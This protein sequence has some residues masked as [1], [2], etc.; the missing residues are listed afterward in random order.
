MIAFTIFFP[1][2]ARIA[3]SRF[4]RSPRLAGLDFRPRPAGSML[5][6]GIY[7]Y[8][9]AAFAA[10]TSMSASAVGIN[11]HSFLTVAACAIAGWLAGFA[12]PGSPAGVR[13][14]DSVIALGLSRLIDPGQA[15]LVARLHRLI[16]AVGDSIL[17]LAGHPVGCFAR[18]AAVKRAS[19]SGQ[20]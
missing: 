1:S 10:T 12:P 16:T 13:T 4:R 11:Q 15:A 9:F 8:N 2:A 6:L 5:C 18:R 14:R 7:A 19:C 17:F 3:Y 20:A